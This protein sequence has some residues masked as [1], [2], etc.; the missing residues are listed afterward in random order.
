MAN[1]KTSQNTKPRPPALSVADGSAVRRARQI[2]SIYN[3]WRRA[4]GVWADRTYDDMPFRDADIG[5]A[6]AAG[7]AALESV[8]DLLTFFPAKHPA[9]VAVEKRL[10]RQMRKLSLNNPGL[11]DAENQPTKPTR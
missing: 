4:E 8:D 2:L 10:W 11:T 5:H 9:R 1:K 3:R 6:I 7:N